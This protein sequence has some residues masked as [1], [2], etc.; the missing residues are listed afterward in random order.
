[1][2][3]LRDNSGKFIRRGY[4]PN[5]SWYEPSDSNTD[6]RAE[7]SKY[8]GDTDP[9]WFVVDQYNR[10]IRMAKYVAMGAMENAF[11]SMD[12]IGVAANDWMADQTS[13]GWYIA[14]ASCDG[15]LGNGNANGTYDE[16]LKYGREQHEKNNR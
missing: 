14:A 7:F 9:K 4:W 15:L 10:P 13:Y 2:P 11:D 6:W 5:K 16:M 1:M 8:V 3:R 12:D